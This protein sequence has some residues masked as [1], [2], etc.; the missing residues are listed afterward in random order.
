MKDLVV[1]CAI[2]P[3]VIAKSLKITQGEN[4]T[5]DEFKRIIQWN[6]KELAVGKSIIFSAEL[7]V[8]LK[9]ILVDDVP[10]IPVLIR[11]SSSADIV[12]S[13]EVD[14]REINGHPAQIVALR[15]HSFRLLH[16]LPS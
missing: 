8:C 1:C 2:P 14:V 3:A 15:H 13:V 7:D 12:S 6:V 11:C 5:F 9:N 10:K 4:G 16:R